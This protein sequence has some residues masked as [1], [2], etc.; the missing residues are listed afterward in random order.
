M[1]EKVIYQLRDLHYKAQKLILNKKDIY[2]L[3]VLHLQTDFILRRSSIIRIIANV[4]QRTV[5]LHLST[6]NAVIQRRV[7]REIQHQNASDEELY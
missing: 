1:N 6:R 7:Q 2:Q 3:C 4:I 5:S